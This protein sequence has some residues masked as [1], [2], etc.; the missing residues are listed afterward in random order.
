MNKGKDKDAVKALAFQ[1]LAQLPIY[2]LALTLKVLETAKDIA[3]KT[4]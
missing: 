4:S 1:L 2:N 3:E